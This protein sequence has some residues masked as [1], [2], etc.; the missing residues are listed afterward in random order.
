[1]NTNITETHL[2]RI[3]PNVI[4]VARKGNVEKLL[5]KVKI[6]FKDVEVI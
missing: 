2:F 1:M 4:A 5:K 3:S 6:V